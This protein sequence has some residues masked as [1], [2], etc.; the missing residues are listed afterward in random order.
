[1]GRIALGICEIWYVCVNHCCYFVVNLCIR[2]VYVYLVLFIYFFQMATNA[3]QGAQGTD[4][5]QCQSVMG[6]IYIP[7]NLYG[8]P[9]GA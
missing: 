4:N 1:M 5:A 6:L 8:C 9:E 7:C 3:R 2:K